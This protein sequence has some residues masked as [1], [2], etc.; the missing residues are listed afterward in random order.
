MTILFSIIAQ[1]IV[2]ATA[3]AI[4]AGHGVGAR[5]QAITAAG[6]KAGLV[7]PQIRVLRIVN[8]FRRPARVIDS[9]LPQR[10]ADRFPPAGEPADDVFL[11]DQKRRQDHHDQRDVFDEGL[12]LY[13][14]LT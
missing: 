11:K 14:A 4:P 13:F 1:G 5:R 8:T 12:G 2:G 6:L 7:I 3:N 9:S 10:L